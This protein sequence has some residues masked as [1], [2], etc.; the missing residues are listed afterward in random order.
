[1]IADNNYP[2]GSWPV[3]QDFIDFAEKNYQ[4]FSLHG[5]SATDIF[6]TDAIWPFE[7]D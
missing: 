4:S 7:N 1:M 5:T 6:N 2:S 3:V